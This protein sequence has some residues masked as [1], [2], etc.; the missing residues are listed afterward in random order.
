MT[1]RENMGFSLKLRKA[2]A[3]T[4][5]QRV[6]DAARILNLD[7]LLERYPRELSGGQ[8]Q[9]VA[10]GRAIVRDPK[11]F[12]FDEPLSNLDAKLRVAMR[13][14]IKALHQRLKT[15]TVYVTHDQI[16]AMTMADRIVVMHD[17]II[18]QIGTPLELFD[19]PGNLFVAQFIGSPAMNVFSGVVRSGQ[20]EGLGAQW[21]L[22]PGMAAEGQA[23]SYGVRPTDLRLAA[24]GIPGRVIIVEPT[25]AETE[26]LVEVGGQQM[27]VVIHGRTQAQPGDPVHLEF[28]VAKSHVF[29]AASGLRL[30]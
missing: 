22:A 8:R 27:V 19:C 4:I 23:V 30:G 7:Q 5:N 14:E 29:D 10:M 28:D 17:G 2:E 25:G 1:V 9:R 16:E 6:A 12:L 11:V 26:L 18:E 24:S 3:K 13:A 15:T 20:V 21:P